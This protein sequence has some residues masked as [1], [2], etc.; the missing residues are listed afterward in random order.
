MNLVGL[1]V[2]REFPEEP[3]VIGDGRGRVAQLTGG[4]GG[5]QQQGVEVREAGHHTGLEAG[6]DERIGTGMITP[7]PD[8]GAGEHETGVTH[9]LGRGQPREQGLDLGHPALPFVARHV[10]IEQQHGEFR[11]GHLGEVIVRVGGQ[12]PAIGGHGSRPVGR[13]AMQLLDTREII[14]RADA[15]VVLRV[16]RAQGLEQLGGRRDISIGPRLDAEERNGRAES[17]LAAGGIGLRRGGKQIAGLVRIQQREFL[18]AGARAGSGRHACG[19][20]GKQAAG[21]GPR[22]R[23]KF[24]HTPEK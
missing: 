23:G 17:G 19:R 15:L 10:V 14:R 13:G 12:Q 9:G 24:S 3:P 4:L 8:Q 20:Q 18:P 21:E 16:F 6:G 22:T 1:D 2:A 11:C 7:Q 5:L